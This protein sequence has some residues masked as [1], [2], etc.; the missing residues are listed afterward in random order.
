MP[1]SI[2]HDYRHAYKLPTP[3]AY[4]KSYSRMLLSSGIGLRS[5]TAI[6]AR[7]AQAKR[8]KNGSSTRGS[9]QDLPLGSE[10]MDRTMSRNTESSVGRAAFDSGLNN[11]TNNNGH[12]A[13]LRHEHLHHIIGQGRISKDQLAMAV[14]KH[15]NSAGLM[16]QEAIARFL[17]KVREEGKG[18]EF[19]LRFQ[20]WSWWRISFAAWIVM[21]I[22]SRW[23]RVACFALR[24]R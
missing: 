5:P 23:W 19:R 10:A 17:Y 21:S 3:S 20:P 15:F 16:E 4:S 12:A 6:A 9:Q 2:L 11:N 24:S 8:Q 13:D 18:R 1:L 22:T 7:R 14:R